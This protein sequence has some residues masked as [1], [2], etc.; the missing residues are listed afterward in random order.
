MIA[1]IAT[2]DRSTCLDRRR[3]VFGRSPPKHLSLRFMRRVLIWEVQNSALGGVSAKVKS[4]LAQIASGKSMPVQ[5]RPGSYLLSEWNGRT[6]QVEV[7]EGAYVIDGKTW[8]SL[9]AMA[10]HITGA[11]WSGPHFFGVQLCVGSFAASTPAKARKSGRNRTSTRS[12]PRGKR[13]RPKS[14]GRSMKAGTCC[15]NGL[16]M[17]G[18]PVDAWTG[19]RRSG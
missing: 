12:M 1:E 10:K 19:L 17:A 13:V 9:S 4:R 8:R 11:H 5:A 7:V 14:L 6:Y 2:L 3:A 18:S 15:R 16:T